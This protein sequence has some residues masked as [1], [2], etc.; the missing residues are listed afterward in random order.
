[1][2]SI[3]DIFALT[4]LQEGMLFH[5]LREPESNVYFEQLGLELTG[6]INQTTFERTWNLIIAGNEAL[7]TVFRWEKMSDPAQ[8]V[9]KEYR[10]EPLYY[11]LYGEDLSVDEIHRRLAEIKTKDRQKQFDLLQTPFRV[12][13]CKMAKDHYEMIISHHHILYD[14]WSNGILLK[15]FFNTYDELS[16]GETP[17]AVFKTRFKEFVKYTREQ[18]PRDRKEQEEYWKG[19]LEGLTEHT[20][21]SIK[22]G[23][24]VK[25]HETVNWQIRIKANIKTKLDALVQKLRITPAA[26]FYTAWGLLLQGYND[27]ND[28]VFGATISGRTPKVKGIENMVGLFINTL[29]LRFKARGEMKIGDVLFDTHQDFQLWEKF[30]STPLVKIKEYC[31]LNLQQE[32]FD[33]LMVV[34]NY[35]LDPCILHKQ[36]SLTPI[37]YSMSAMTHYDLTAA[38]TLG[39]EI[40]VIFSY[41]ASLFEQRMI[42]RM[43]GHFTC[44]LE[45]MVGNPGKR[46]RDIE[47]LTP[48]EKQYLLEEF[49]DTDADFPCD[50]TIHELFAEQV[51]KTPDRIALVGAALYVRPVGLVS[52]SYRQLNK[53]SG[54]LAHQ[55]QDK[56]V[57]PDIIVG[58]MMERSIEMVI[59]ILGILKSGSVYLPIDPEYPE[60]RIQYML[61][62]SNAKILLGKEECQK[63]IIVNCQLLIVNCKLMGPPPAPFHHS[64]FIVHHSNH[65]AYIIYTSGTTGKPKGVAVEHSGLV[66]YITWRLKSYDYRVEDVTLQLLSYSFDGFSSNFYSSL[67]S[68]GILVLT[69]EV[70]KLDFDFIVKILKQEGVTNISLTPGMY[71]AL[72]QSVSAKQLDSLRFV[73]LAGEKADSGLIVSGK[74]KNPR[75]Q[76]IIEYGP[77]E[78]TVTAAANM[79]IE[80]T[81]TSIIGRPIANVEIYIINRFFHPVPV[82]VPGELCIAG[83]GLAR[84][85]L[86][87]PELTAEKFINRSF[88]GGPGGRL[89]KKAPLVY[90]TGDLARWFSDGSIEFL[91]RKD[92][93]VKIR[94]FRIEP[95]EIER[96]LLRHPCIREVVVTARPNNNETQDKYLCA[97]IVLHPG[98]TLAAAALRDFLSGLLP[99]YMIPSYFIEMERIPLTPTGKIDRRIL[100]APDD[101]GAGKI[102]TAPRN[103]LEM[104][105]AEIWAEVLTNREPEPLH[106]GIDDNFF[107]LGGHSLKAAALTAR[108]HKYLDIKISLEELFKN[109]TIR[110]LAANIKKRR[111]LQVY[112]AVEPGEEKDYYPV[113][114]AQQRL[115]ILQQ[116]D[117]IG[118]AYNMPTV[119]LLE[120]M[121]DRDKLAGIFKRLINRHESMRTSFVLVDGTPVQRIHKNVDIALEYYNLATAEHEQTRTFLGTEGKGYH[122]SFIIHHFIRAFDL[123][124]APLLRVGLIELGEGRCILI[125]DVHHIAADGV[126]MGILITEMM[127]LYRD[128]TVALPGLRLQYKD[129]SE[130]QNRWDDTKKEAYRQQKEYWQNE[131]A[132]EL[133]VLGLP[134]DY[135]RP[136][137]QEF[138]GDFM[139]FEPAPGDIEALQALA[140]AEG[141]TLYMVLLAAYTIFLAK[142]CN[143]EDIIL[144]IPAAGR[145]HSDLDGVM[146]MFVNTLVL[147]HE[148]SGQKTINEFT[149]EVT[150]K[151]LAALA[152][153]DVQFEELLELV[154]GNNE[155]DLSRNPLFDVMFV[156]Q[157]VEIPGFEIPGLQ[158]KPYPYETDTSK[159]DLILHFM[160]QGEAVWF[161]FEYSTKLFKKSTIKRFTGY[162]LEVLKAFPNGSEKRLREIDV[163]PE[164]EKQWLLFEFN[165]TFAE[166][167]QDKTIHELFADQVEKAPD[168]IALLGQGAFLKNRPADTDPQKT[169]YY[170]TYRQLHKQS[171]QLAHQLQDKGVGP[172]IIV[173][174]MTERSI[175]MIIGIL[176][177]LK[178]G[179]AYLPIDPE[180]PQERIQYMLEDSNASIL[181]AT[182]EYQKKIIVNCQLLIVN[183]KLMAPF[184][185]SF[186]H[187]SFTVHH[188]SHLSYIIYTS[189]TT[190]KPKGVLIEHRSVVQL[191]FNDKFQFDFNEKDTWTM[192]HSYCFDFSVW[193]MYGALLYGG[194]LVLISKTTARDMSRYLELLKATGVTVL[195]QTPSAFYM[196]A[197]EELKSPGKELQLRYVIFGGE[198]LWP[199][200]LKEWHEKY[201]HTKLINMFGITETTVHVTY[202]EIGAEEIRLNKSNIGKPLPTL[203]TYIMNNYS[204]LVPIGT[205]GELIVGGWGTARGYLNRPELSAEKFD[206]D[207]KNKSFYGGSRGAVFSKKA[208]LVYRSGDLG[209]F[210]T[211]GELEYLGRI[212]H[213]VKIRG[214]RI[215][216]AEIET[217]LTQHE[218]VKESVVIAR[219]DHSGDLYLCAYIV[220]HNDSN[221]MPLSPSTTD[222]DLR[223]Y[224]SRRLPDYM[225]PAYFIPID[226]I[227]LTPNGKLDRQRLPEPG[228]ITAGG[229][230][231]EAPRNEAE[232][233]MAEV[234]GHILGLE[235]PG[236]RNSFFTNGGDSI[237]AVRFI[238]LLNE[239]LKTNLKIKDLYAHPTIEELA[240]LV[241]QDQGEDSAAERT[242]VEKK[243]E[244]LKQ[245]VMTEGNF[246]ETEIEDIYPMS[247][248]EKGLVFYYLKST[249]TVVYHDQ[250]IY[251]LKY[252]EFDAAVYKRALELVMEKHPI[253]R[254]GFN[255]EDFGES[256]QIVYREVPVD[257]PHYHIAHLDRQGQEAYIKK[258]LAED[259]K[260]P[261]DAAV[262]PLLRMSVFILDNEDIRVVLV[263]HHAVLDGWSAA[264][265]MTELHNTYLRLKSNPH[266]VLPKLKS[267]YRDV[268][269]EE[270]IEKSREE[271]HRFWLLELQDYKRLEFPRVVENPG[272]FTGMRTHVHH[273][274]NELLAILKKTAH[275]YGTSLKDL[276]LGAYIYVLAMLCN[277]SD[278][279]AGC[280]THNRPQKQDGDKVLG[281]FLNTVPVRITIPPGV[282]W[283]GYF[284]MIAAKMLEIKK[285]ERVSLFEIAR[286]I[287]EKSQEQNP[288]FDTLFNFVDFHVYFDADAGP[289]GIN[290]IETGA[291]STEGNQDT[292]TLFDFEISITF[293]EFILCPKYNYLAVSDEM[294]QRS[295]VYFERILRK[296][297]HEPHAV[298]R[299]GDILP[300]EEKRK[301]LE[302]FNDTVAFYDR[303]RILPGLFEGQVERAP[304]HMA[305]TGGASGGL[306]HLTYGELN[307]RA[308]RLARALQEKGVRT[309]CLVGVVM[310]R[311]I[312]MITAVMAILK[313][314]GAYVP[315]EPYL[316]DTRIKKLLESLDVKYLVTGYSQLAKVSLIVEDLPEL[317]HIFCLP[318]PVAGGGV[319]DWLPELPAGK[320]FIFHHEIDKQ[321]PGNVLHLSA[322]GD[323]AYIIFTSGSTGIP[324]GVVLRHRPVVNVIRWVNKTFQV[325]PGD[326]VL[327]VSSLGFDLSV[328]DIFGILACGACIRMAA[329]GDL[330]E[331]RRLLDI[332]LEEGITFW[333]S[334]PAALQQLSPFFPEV[335]NS[336]HHSRLRLVFLSGDWIPITL[337]DA[338][339]ETFSVVNVISLGGA[340]EAAIW[341]NYHPIGNVDPAWVSIPYG[342]PIQNAQYYILDPGLDICP[343]MVPGDLYIGGECLASGYINDVELTAEKFCLVKSFAGVQGGLFQKPPLV[344]YRTGDMARWFIDGS[345]EFLGRKDQQVKIRGFRIELG[346]IESH[347]QHHQEIEDAVVI[348]VG[349]K[350]TDKFLCAYFVSDKSLEVPVLEKYLAAELPDYMIPRYFIQ[351]ERIPLTANGKVDRKSL[352][353]PEEAG[354]GMPYAAPRNGIEEKLATIWGDVLAKNTSLPIGIDDNFFELGGHSLNAAIVISKIHKVL[355]VKIPLAELF[356]KPTI[357]QLVGVIQSSAEDRLVSV[358]AEEEKEYYILSSAQERL[359]ILQQMSPANTAYNIPHMLKLEGIIDNGKLEQV[360]KELIR[361]H[362]SFRTSFVTVADEPVQRIRDGVEFE[363]EYY[364]LS[365]DYTDYTDNKDD[366]I[367]HSSFMDTPNHFIRAF[368]LS[369][370]PLLRVG[371]VKLAEQEHILILD[372]HHIISDGTS[373]GILTVEA[374]ALYN[375]EKLPALGVHYRDY[376]AWQGAWKKSSSYK[377]Q[378]TFW[379]RQFEA[380]MPVLNLPSDRPRPEVQR[381]EGRSVFF[382]LGEKITAALHCLALREGATLYMT[383]LAAFYVFL[384]KL[385][386]QEDIVIGSPVEGRRHTDLQ[387]II[388]MFVNTLA[389]RNFPAGEKNFTEFL[390]ELKKRTLSAFENQDF[391]FED[392]VV[393]LDVPRDLSRNPV[394]DV[395]FVLQNMESPGVHLP[396]L[397]MTSSPFENNTSKFD[398]TLTAL[399]R[400][401]KMQLSFEYSTA[402]FEEE[403]ILRS[404]RYFKNILSSII[405]TPGQKISAI[406]IMAEE[407]KKRILHDFNDTGAPYPQGRAIH[408]LFEEQVERTPDHI[409]IVGAANSVG[410]VGPVRPVRL[411]Y[412]E[413]NERSGKLAGVLIEKGVL[414]DNII[415]IMIDRSI[416]MMIG[417]Y[418]ILKAGGAYLPID[419][420]YPQE[421]IDYMLKDSG[422][423]VLLGMEECQ[424]KIMVNCQ[425]LIVNCKLLMSPPQ[426][427]FHHSSLIVHHSNHL[428]YIIYTSGTTGKPKGAAIEHHSL[429][430]RLSW[431]Q[432]QYPLSETDV[433]LHKTP[434]TFD[435]SVWEIFWWGMVGAGVCLLAPGGERDPQQMMNAIERSRVTVM[436]FVPSML[437][438]F[439]EYIEGSGV[440]GG[441][442]SLK[443]VVASGEA[444]TAALVIRFNEIL[445]KENNVRLANLYG[446]TEATID[447]SFYDCPAGQDIERI[448]IGRPIDN[449][450][451]Y[452]FSKD[453]QLQP[454][455]VPGEL[456]IAGVG[457]ARGYLNRPELTNRKFLLDKSFS[458]GAGGRFFKKAPLHY[459]TGDLAR[460]L[461]DGNIEYLGR[462]DQQVKVRGFRIELEEIERHLEHHKQIKGAVV[463]VESDGKADNILCAYVVSKAGEELSA[464]QLRE[465][466]VGR[467]PGYMVPVV[468][469]QLDRIPLSPN[470]KVDR[471]RLRSSGARLNGGRKVQYVAPGTPTETRIAH[472]WKEILSLTGEGEEIGIHDNFFDIGGTSMDVIKVNSRINRE[473]EKQI[474]IVAMYKYTTIRTLAQ[475]LEQGETRAADEYPESERTD[476]IERGRTDKSRMREMR[477]RGRR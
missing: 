353:V 432:K 123:S 41:P 465:Y 55:L 86:N 472:T 122:S 357:R 37:S 297:I 460:W 419:P 125:V 85:Y 458:G 317:Q 112:S 445:N 65:L 139:K 63:K 354:A 88:S 164:I 69:P 329:A 140:R 208:P 168:H 135:K 362:E 436:H 82:G 475:F 116:K 347:L 468:Y 295:C 452:I 315:M 463:T 290:N 224:L 80:S 58:I 48:E 300:E 71:V 195:N 101:E 393:R 252:P 59:G 381:F 459:K 54:Q 147:G 162:F 344:L 201:P 18:D 97:Y 402:L 257:L 359:Y 271:I 311:S 51:E 400:E 286:V 439:L 285:H 190:G 410:Q 27:C 346:E 307:E 231:Y 316:P 401:G 348:A 84:G 209:R 200:R 276:C 24:A 10:L 294:V 336:S 108:I 167:P 163:L 73:V 222:A 185:A 15:E 113:S 263:F 391:P 270:I 398:L 182:E 330:K 241:Q 280:V 467:L 44:I 9:M 239:R 141:T 225:V 255:V 306:K 309:E 318:S 215:E 107:A 375:N 202:K 427:T 103:D 360:F 138:A 473:F 320:T 171:G 221:A 313:A 383:L 409:A 441:L 89:F 428:A 327:F 100:P 8:M 213:Q 260:H 435:V 376:T 406:E 324:K 53:Q 72:L 68:G 299:K 29:P 272:P 129:Y 159:F 173:G 334:A 90:R 35:P 14:G 464:S 345:M 447:V 358:E 364:N 339:K 105:L 261:F 92:Q 149:R 405:E 422:A 275:D 418:G 142:I 373:M 245:Q 153:Q 264:S 61:E 79:D 269:V 87:R 377:E 144:G 305:V 454:V 133:P 430:N 333:D 118:T 326:K 158:V 281:C 457:L 136:A 392:L 278:I 337:P 389:L 253:L 404:T 152:N 296:F 425:L 181:L 36:K 230:R 211:E 91:G 146:G 186:H 128:A 217:R 93:Q 351:V 176:G 349:E 62:D 148:P 249:G 96:Q 19:Y 394:F 302:E 42:E 21:L 384:Y 416:E 304:G 143:Q 340:T 396:G 166:F 30:S 52:L 124:N 81:G 150:T 104:K 169:F 415:G 17:A 433:I 292:N 26:V 455:G 322:S 387:R 443:Q 442:S 450:C 413:L 444:L 421:R 16:R 214:F 408:E 254:T 34:E 223:E 338:L 228:G 178:A 312:E 303:D 379:G 247:D 403:T 279:T 180:S 192:F 165:K 210:S 237:K 226:K 407:E 461:A 220:F 75:I 310:D 172:D 367:H 120:G 434:F 451:L 244:T 32:L 94:G 266:L 366:K 216:L 160:K 471:K 117:D 256:V 175:E 356:H 134:V 423:K 95:E 370:A 60:E 189:G 233:Q 83:V 28:M 155:R 191:L 446:P 240:E 98:H 298:A 397:T 67:L 77:T 251:P 31:G 161:K 188:S 424:K 259:K 429:V 229:V 283:A 102:Y 355:N 22:T 156:Q 219:T 3:E 137:I 170:L 382:E 99:D 477:K 308:N 363:I 453:R 232:K 395:M 431:M 204:M 12:T 4:P 25:S 126:S 1:M 196:L 289:T 440:A 274:G 74:E 40:D 380:E 331:P 368:D 66:N 43:A 390:A 448:P 288:I 198:A 119:L 218:N 399:E 203:S 199:G 371:L 207:E 78:A 64:S 238:G 361:R 342:K 145:K 350:A 246:R 109:P 335:K 132:G 151:A 197:E 13:L 287:G 70:R 273:L 449:I 412:R 50:K 131:L 76:H 328:Y 205:A 374:M 121:V 369:K 469:K 332:I 11:D 7:R 417:I 323:I 437:R 106:V 265:L 56:G 114:S 372:M 386:S 179:G 476:K 284:N 111:D 388:G 194:K 267:S 411:S 2:K 414:A 23:R 341:S 470:G 33:T 325:G 130:W 157:E 38:V 183:C 420:G 385:G 282:D 5:Y 343:L 474:P 184:P 314:G 293:G 466:L 187:S 277:E 49:N 462:I 301:I 174:I 365:T 426:E 248:I 262:P 250:F 243:I 206:Q 456:Y 235:R 46:L 57:G 6:N 291:F 127:I 177:I 193:E 154:G 227:P 319:P 234:F 321:A 115:Y 39:E 268:I 242:E 212:D 258:Y 438:A 47:R 378:E 352:P 20:E 236:I 110:E 45:E